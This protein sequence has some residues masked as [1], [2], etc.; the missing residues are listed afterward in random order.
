MPESV[1]TRIKRWIYN[2]YPVYRR[3]GARIDYIDDSRRI[4]KIIIMNDELID[5]ESHE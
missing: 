2:F 1:Q 5:Q 3:T 4:E